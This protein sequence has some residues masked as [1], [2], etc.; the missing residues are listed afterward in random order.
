MRADMKK[1]TVAFRNFAKSAKN[2]YRTI[3]VFFDVAQ[4]AGFRPI[5]RKT[6]V[7]LAPLCEPEISRGYRNLQ[8]HELKSLVEWK[9]DDVG[10]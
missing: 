5:Q 3:L 8:N 2:A 4:V 7:S 9:S 1:L 6:H 10:Q